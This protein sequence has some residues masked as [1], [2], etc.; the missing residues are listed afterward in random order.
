[1]KVSGC[2]MFYRVK[3]VKPLKP[4]EL[5]V[6]FVTGEQKRYDVAQLCDR[7]E[8]FRPLMDVQGLFEQVKVDRGG[9]GISW[10][11]DIDLSCN[12]LWSNGVSL[13]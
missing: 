6:S 3:E 5:L 2:S 13:W 8:A 10:N 1:M 9:Y 7:W 11:D 12:E 4:Y